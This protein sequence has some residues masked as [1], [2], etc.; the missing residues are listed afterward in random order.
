MKNATDLALIGFLKIIANLNREPAILAYRNN[1]EINEVMP[2]FKIKMGFGLHIGINSL[3][4]KVGPLKEL[5]VHFS[6]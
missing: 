6:K 4:S 5:S 2:N 1:K 3:Y